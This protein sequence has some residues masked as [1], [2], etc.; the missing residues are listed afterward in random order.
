MSYSRFGWD[1]SDVYL[2]AAIEDGVNVIHCEQCILAMG[3]F[4]PD[5][6]HPLGGTVTTKEEILTRF[7]SYPQLEK[8]IEDHRH[9]GHHVPT[10]VDV[11]ILREKEDPAEAWLQL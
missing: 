5:E 11:R 6:L 10:Y 2:Y 1:G 8:H 3:D 9:V 4:I 7:T